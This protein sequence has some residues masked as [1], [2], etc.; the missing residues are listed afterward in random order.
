MKTS[1]ST[2]LFIRTLFWYLQCAL[3]IK[4]KVKVEGYDTT[5]RIFCVHMCMTLITCDILSCV[6]V[7]V[8]WALRH[9]GF[10]ANILPLFTCSLG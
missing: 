8:M 3:S 10:G 1:V 7:A 2:I 5:E 6:P 4:V 9:Y